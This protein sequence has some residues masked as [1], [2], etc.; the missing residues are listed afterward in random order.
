MKRGGEEKFGGWTGGLDTVG[1]LE[2]DG[3]VGKG[4]VGR[5]DGVGAAGA[6]EVVKVPPQGRHQQR[7]HWPEVQLLQER[8]LQR[9]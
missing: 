9:G 6:S 1:H 7:G 4:H 5:V 8:R 3:I 2:H